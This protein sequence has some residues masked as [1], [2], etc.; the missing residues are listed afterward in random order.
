MIDWFKKKQKKT[1]SAPNKPNNLGLYARLKLGLHNT[2]HKLNASIHNVF[3]GQKHLTA[4]MLDEIE[5]LLISADLGMDVVRMIMQDINIAWTRA[6]PHLDDA[7]QPEEFV[8]NII[9]QKLHSVL[10]TCNSHLEINNTPF[11][12]LTVGING[13]GKTTTIGK[14][15]KQLQD[16]G[17]KVMLVAGDTFRAAAIEQLTE[18]GKRNQIPVIAQ[19]L[20]ADSASVIY[21][22]LQ[23]A[24]TRKVDVLLIDTAGRLHTHVNLMNEL[25]KIKRILQK[26]DVTAP[27]EIMLVLDANIGLNAINQVREFHKALGLTGIVMTKLDGTAK[28]GILFGI[29]Q[30]FGIP[31]RYLG[32]GEGVCDLRPFDATQFV[33]AI[34]DED[35]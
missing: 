1:V 20:G 7:L 32:M 18:L 14:L 35:D 33:S 11:V 12:I 28:G 29:V 3:Y 13:A 24:I 30:N 23:A 22:G 16:Q 5:T 19:H 6:K 27:H 26:L 10:A 31:I 9:K 2:S 21:D 15:A 25:T 4:S 34:L 17:K 8:K